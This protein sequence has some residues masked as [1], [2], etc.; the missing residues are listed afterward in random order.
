MSRPLPLNMDLKAPNLHPT[1][2]LT[3]APKM[4]VCL[5]SYSAV[6]VSAG[7]KFSLQCVNPSHLAS[8][9][10]KQWSIHQCFICMISPEESVPTVP[11]PG[12]KGFWLNHSRS[13]SVSLDQSEARYGHADQ[14][15]APQHHLWSRKLVTLH[16]IYELH[17]HMGP[18]SSNNQHRPG[19]THS[20]W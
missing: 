16:S 9:N 18:D 19:G 5:D 10:R 17:P 20:V 7:S 3:L 15:E 4:N 14:W 12:Y 2:L 1:K 8:V 11:R 13:W 6:S